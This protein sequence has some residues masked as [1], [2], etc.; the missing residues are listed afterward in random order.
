MAGRVI[1]PLKQQ[2]IMEFWSA[3]PPSRLS[4]Y[5]E[6]WLSPFPS[7]EWLWF[8]RKFKGNTAPQVLWN[9][10]HAAQL[11]THTHTCV[12]DTKPCHGTRLLLSH[13]RALGTF[14]THW[15]VM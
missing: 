15:K 12:T 1:L 7:K 13:I 4:L 10:S 9:H 3:T 8:N 6:M 14:G 11:L 2:L 5:V